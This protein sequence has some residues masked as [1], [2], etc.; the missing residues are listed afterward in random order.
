MSQ[1][2]LSP[3]RAY[4][5]GSLSARRFN[6]RVLKHLGVP[7][8]NL[9]FRTDGSDHLV[10][11]GDV[12][13][14]FLSQSRELQKKF[15]LRIESSKDEVVGRVF[16]VTNSFG[17]EPTGFHVNKHEAVCRAVLSSHPAF[18]KKIWRL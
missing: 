5:P 1:R 12:E 10:F 16:R 9:V 14:D 17:R 6:V 13:Y 2:I 18:A 3:L 4:Y 15:K 7:T 11:L 8:E